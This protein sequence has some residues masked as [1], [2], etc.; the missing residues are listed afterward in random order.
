MQ[1]SVTL[2]AGRSLL[3]DGLGA[4]SPIASPQLQKSLHGRGRVVLV[5]VVRVGEDSLSLFE[6]AIHDASPPQQ[7]IV[8]VLLQMGVSQGELAAVSE[9]SVVGEGCC[10]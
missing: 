10:R 9:T 1:F 3:Q 7:V 5:V 4:S 8:S 6:E 2:G